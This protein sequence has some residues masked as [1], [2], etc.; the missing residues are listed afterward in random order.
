MSKFA[1]RLNIMIMKHLSIKEKLISVLHG[2]KARQKKRHS[3]AINHHAANES[4]SDIGERL[5]EWVEEKQFADESIRTVSD[6]AES[7]GIGRDGLARYFA[8]VIK[9]DPRTWIVQ[10][11]IEMAEEMLIK[12]PECSMTI[13]GDSVGFSDRSNFARQ[14]KK[15]TGM[16]PGCWKERKLLDSG[17]KNVDPFYFE[18]V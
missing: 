7:I 12:Y 1:I 10:R 4:F 15:H 16:T 6:I 9:E 3:R 11:K 14:F 13:I 8:M 17:E 5:I 2:R 18:N